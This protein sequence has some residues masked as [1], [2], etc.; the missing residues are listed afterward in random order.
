MANLNFQIKKFLS[1]KNTVT[2]LGVL[3]IVMVL[4]FGYNWRVRQAINPIPGVPYAKVTIQPRT[5]IT[6]DMIGYTDVAPVMIRGRIIRNANVIIGNWSNYNTMIPAGSLFYQESITATLPDSAFVNIPVGFTAFNLPVDI[7]TT[8]GN[9]IFPG[10]YIDIYLKALNE[11]GKIIVGKLLANVE[12]LAVKDNSGR[13]VFEDTETRRTPSS[14]IF[15]VPEDIHILLRKALYLRNVRDVAAELI[16][17]PSTESY[18]TDPG[19]IRMTSQFLRNFIEINTGFVMEDELP[20]ASEPED[21]YEE[22]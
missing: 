2:I 15:A 12:V 4:Y 6:A 1:N 18:S 14:I 5:K 22:D 3:A 7:H 17:V 16:P 19:E 21:Y 13:H 9:S 10:N 8:Y 11:E 20:D